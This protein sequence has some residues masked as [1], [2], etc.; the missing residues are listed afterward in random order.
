MFPLPNELNQDIFRLLWKKETNMDS[1][2]TLLPLSH[3]SNYT[4]KQQVNKQARMLIMSDPVLWKFFRV[5][6]S[7]TRTKGYANLSSLIA[8]VFSNETTASFFQAARLYMIPV[9]S[10]AVIDLLKLKNLTTLNVR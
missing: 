4:F 10:S 1:L 9:Q 6:L 2:W 5:G 8:S 7:A 3:V